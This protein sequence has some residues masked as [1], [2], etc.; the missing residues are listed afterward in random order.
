M[1]AFGM[2]CRSRLIPVVKVGLGGAKRIEGG[3]HTDVV[4]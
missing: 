3:P 1:R 4:S 2:T